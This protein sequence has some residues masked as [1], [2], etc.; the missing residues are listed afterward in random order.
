MKQNKITLAAVLS[1]GIC[2]CFL[3]VFC[4]INFRGFA[5]FCTPDMYSDTLLSRYIWES[6]SI[7]PENWI[8][9]NQFYVAATPVLAALMYGLCG[10][11]NTAMVLATTAMTVL[12]LISFWWML[13][14]YADGSRI[15]LGMAVL[16]GCVIGPNIV[17]TIEGQIF[18]LMASYYAGYLITLFVVFGDY[19]HTLTHTPSR[20][21]N[22]SMWLSLLLS[23]CTGM[24]SLRQTAVMILPLLGFECLRLLR[25]WLSRKESRDWNREAAF[26]VGAYTLA[27]L[28]GRVAIKL[29]DPNCVT[30]YED[31]A[32]NS[33][34]VLWERFTTCLRA[35]RSVS[36][37]KYLT[38]DTPLAGIAALVLVLTVAAALLILLRRRPGD[39]IGALTLLLTF[40]VLGVLGVSM[41]VNIYIRS[42]YVF[43]WYPLTALAAVLL[44]G[45]LRGWPRTALSLT[46]LAALM[47][48]LW[49][50]YGPTAALA[51]EDTPPP[52]RQVAQ[53]LMDEDYDFVY[54]PWMEVSG[55]AVWT[56]GQ[57]AAGSW[58]ER[59]CQVIPYITPTD[60]FSQEDNTR[61]CYL[62]TGPGVEQALQDR[63][64]AQGATLTL[65]S[66]FEG[67]AYALYTS[68]RQLM[69]FE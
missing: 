24:Q 45:Q 46:L 58:H 21:P 28:A 49:V 30:M 66:R 44:A 5:R 3:A 36:G 8:F 2:L 53:Y 4:V 27:N 63:A 51:L 65:V 40:S 17:T 18:Y 11:V 29:L 59:V 41:V 56:D 42:I 1:A 15:L 9:G 68:D 33:P 60:I 61:A 43:P 69:Y 35:L 50:S 23:F 34:Q 26:R 12:T 6:G 19:V 10:S 47:G 16:L 7:F 52:E 38:G 32:F 31:L 55:V 62:T 57:V 64:A 67:T 22:V 37:L 48:N 13:R 14:P 20:R 54:G 25:V 39:G